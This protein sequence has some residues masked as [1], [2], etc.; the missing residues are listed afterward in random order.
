MVVERN[1]SSNVPAPAAGSGREETTMGLRGGRWAAG[2]LAVVL[3]AGCGSGF[4]RDPE[5]TLERVRGGELRAGVVESP[6]WTEVPDSGRPSGIEVDLVEDF[7]RRLDAEVVWVSGSESHLIRSL[8]S[9]ELDVVAAG[10]TETAPWEK[11]AALT[12]P[13]AEI[14]T[15]DGRTEKM[16]LATRLGENGFLT[17]L[18]TFLVEREERS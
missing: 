3:L 11:H 12:R 18:E 13:H 6:P 7:A 5:G 1:R 15:P 4:P 2:A 14:A 16:V 8:E 10:L 9:G 17:E